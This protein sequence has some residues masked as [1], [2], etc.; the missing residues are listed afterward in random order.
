MGEESLLAC[1]VRE[2][3]EE[4]GVRVTPLAVRCGTRATP[5]E[6]ALEGQQE[7]QEMH[8]VQHMQAVQ[9]AQA[10]QAMQRRARGAH[11]DVQAVES[12]AEGPVRQGLTEGV[13]HYEAV[14]CCHWA[15]VATGAL[16]MVFYYAASADESALPEPLVGE[17][18]GL[19]ENVWCEVDEAAK[20][21]AFPTDGMVVNKAVAD[22][23]RTGYDI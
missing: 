23:R 11:V 19:F 21:L 14:A 10:M 16:K 7:L 15:D 9:A 18:A 2:T 12:D 3:L 1:A 20:Q 4:T 17:D 6:G 22:M 5:G 8:E 13:D